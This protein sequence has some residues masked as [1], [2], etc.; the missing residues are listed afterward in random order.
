MTTKERP[1]NLTKVDERYGLPMPDVDKREIGDLATWSV[2]TAKAAN[3][4]ELLRDNNG[5]TYWQ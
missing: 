5:E 4:V 1:C 3:G 2:T